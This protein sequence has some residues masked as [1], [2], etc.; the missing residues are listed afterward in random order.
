[1]KWDKIMRKQVG[2]TI[3]LVLLASG[4]RFFSLRPDWVETYYSAGIYPQIG[5]SMRRIFGWLPFSLGDLLYLLAVLWLFYKLIRLIKKII[6]GKINRANVYPIVVK[7]VNFLLIIYIYFNLF[8]GLNYNRL[9]ISEQLKL[10][11]IE[12]SRNQLE[13]ITGLL[14]L[15]TNSFAVAAGLR[16]KPEAKTVF[17]TSIENYQKLGKT[18]P[19]L[20]YHP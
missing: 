19:F 4:V 8:W 12:P 15:R 2:W 5:K 16:N 3:I 6:E 7:W 17:S 9:G 11:V 13:T 1:M 18:Y 20:Q 10:A 14:L